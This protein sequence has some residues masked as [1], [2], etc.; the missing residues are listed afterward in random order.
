MLLITL[1]TLD[2]D[3]KGFIFIWLYSYLLLK[4]FERGFHTFQTEMLKYKSVFHGN[5]MQ[6][7]VFSHSTPLSLVVPEFLKI[8]HTTLLYYSIF[9]TGQCAWFKVMLTSLGGN[10]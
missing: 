4:T 1:A 9:I 10:E 2:V 5:E 3:F 7:M 6:W 8:H